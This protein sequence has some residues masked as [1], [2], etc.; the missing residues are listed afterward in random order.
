MSA[1]KLYYFHIA[2]SRRGLDVDEREGNC[3]AHA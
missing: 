1:S 3:P 2:M